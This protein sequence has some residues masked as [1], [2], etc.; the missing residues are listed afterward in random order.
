MRLLFMLIL[1]F[2]TF[3][4]AHSRDSYAPSAP[5]EAQCELLESAGKN[6]EDDNDDIP[7]RLAL[8]SVRNPYFYTEETKEI[9]EICIK[10]FQPRFQVFSVNRNLWLF[11]NPGDIELQPYRLYTYERWA[12]RLGNKTSKNPQV[13]KLNEKCK[14][15]F[16]KNSKPASSIDV[17]DDES[18]CIGKFGFSVIC[19][20][21]GSGYTRQALSRMS[22]FH[23]AFAHLYENNGYVDHRTT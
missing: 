16:T 11:V 20:S 23:E 12:D 9:I 17:L 7:W 3:S 10:R 18:Y 21:N 19:S 4:S 22:Y 13:R 8:D 14:N 6:A 5:G 15:A 1:F 2:A